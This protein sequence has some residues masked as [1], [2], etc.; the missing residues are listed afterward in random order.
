MPIY[1]AG[2]ISEIFWIEKGNNHESISYPVHV[3][4]KMTLIWSCS[5]LCIRRRITNLHCWINFW[6]IL[7]RKSNS[8]VFAPWINLLYRVLE[9]DLHFE[10]YL[11]LHLEY[12]STLLDQFLRYFERSLYGEPAHMAN[13][14]L[15]MA[16][17]HM[18][19]RLWQIGMWQKGIWQNVRYTNLNYRTN[20]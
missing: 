15:C 8:Q 5:W 12:Y 7:D 11:A 9:N 10:L 18:A 1:S 6:D 20:F 17:R 16:N 4:L 2:P 14:G 3:Y 13:C 19:N